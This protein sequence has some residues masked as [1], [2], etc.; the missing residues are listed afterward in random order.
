ML[1]L[2]TCIGL[3]LLLLVESR[4]ALD[5]NTSWVIVGFPKFVWTFLE[6]VETESKGVER[7]LNN[8]QEQARRRKGETVI[9]IVWVKSEQ[10]VARG[11]GH[12]VFVLFSASSTTIIPCTL[13]VA[14]WERTWSWSV[15]DLFH[16]TAIVY[17]ITC[18]IS[19]LQDKRNERQNQESWVVM[20]R[21]AGWS[22]R[23][24]SL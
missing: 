20:T 3:P 21:L 19:G 15:A 13:L 23:G 6:P 22:S 14:Q 16:S 10:L 5:Q 17:K 9:P 1:T 18:M 11:S 7:R 24:R 8:E 2:W 4:S 12:S